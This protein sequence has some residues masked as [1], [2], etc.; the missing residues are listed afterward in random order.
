MKGLWRMIPYK[1]ALTHRSSCRRTPLFD[2]TLWTAIN[3][4][5][6][7]QARAKPLAGRASV[8]FVFDVPGRLPYWHSVRQT[9]AHAPCTCS[10]GYRLLLRS[11]PVSILS[12]LICFSCFFLGGGGA[13]NPWRGRPGAII[14]LDQL[15]SPAGAALISI[16]PSP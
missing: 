7:S 3:Q 15:P 9:E 1:Q 10:C 6:Q 11:S 13:P 8:L 16:V 2:Q 5:S 4:P 14:C 12:I